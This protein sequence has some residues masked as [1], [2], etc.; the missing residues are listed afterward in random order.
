M[1]VLSFSW[2]GSQENV[3]LK[4]LAGGRGGLSAC[5]LSA[6]RDVPPR[7]VAQACRWEWV[8]GTYVSLPADGSMDGQACGVACRPPSR[9][10]AVVHGDLGE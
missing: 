6:C 5:I 1:T 3:L 8:W 2:L 7:A 10:R 9:M 4:P